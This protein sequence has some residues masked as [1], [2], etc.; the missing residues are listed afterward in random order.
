M[1]NKLFLSLFLAS[2]APDSLQGMERG[3]T[4]KMSPEKGGASKSSDQADIVSVVPRVNSYRWGKPYTVLGSQFEP[5]LEVKGESA[6]GIIYIR[7]SND[8]HGAGMPALGYEGEYYQ[9]G[10]SSAKCLS[11]ELAAELAQKAGLRHRQ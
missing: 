5:S 4:G 10:E 7:K 9:A 8:S 6:S 11:P 2:F 1:N 3:Y